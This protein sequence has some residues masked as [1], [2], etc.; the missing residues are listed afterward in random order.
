MSSSISGEDPAQQQISFRITVTNTG[1]DVARDVQVLLSV[2][3]TNEET[4]PV[5][6]EA[7]PSTPG[8]VDLG[9]DESETYN[10]TWRN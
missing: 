2:M 10:I 3:A 1:A 8:P 6:M 7:E 5:M 4:K 9:P